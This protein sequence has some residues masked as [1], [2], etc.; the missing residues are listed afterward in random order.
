MGVYKICIA[1]L[2]EGSFQYFYH[3]SKSF[4]LTNTAFNLCTALLYHIWL[5]DSMNSMIL[6]RISDNFCHK[7]KTKNLN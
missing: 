5:M 6:S 2:E 4:K 3:S 7:S 1:S